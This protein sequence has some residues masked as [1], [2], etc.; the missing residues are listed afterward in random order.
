MFQKALRE[1]SASVGGRRRTH[2]QSWELSGTGLM[3][4]QT[5]Q[6]GATGECLIDLA[7]KALLGC[8]V[9]IPPG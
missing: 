5:R 8:W 1:A 7:V 6:L 4:L 2:Y 3:E 9:V